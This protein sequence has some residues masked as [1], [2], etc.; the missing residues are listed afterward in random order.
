MF[1]TG[2]LNVFTIASCFLVFS[3]HSEEANLKVACISN[4]D[5]KNK[6][7]KEKIVG[8]FSFDTFFKNT[9]IYIGFKRPFLGINE[10][11]ATNTKCTASSNGGVVDP[12]NGNVATHIVCVEDT[13]IPGERISLVVKNLLGDKRE[14]SFIPRQIFVESKDKQWSLNVEALE[15]NIFAITISGIE[16]G[17][18]IKVHAFSGNEVI[19]AEHEAHPNIPI[20]IFPATTGA[21][22]GISIVRIERSEGRH[23]EVYLPWGTELK[24]FR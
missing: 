21:S 16:P 3:N 20:M 9:D 5:L 1:L 10:E 13:F 15:W 24:K 23:L 18:L 19:K 2:L 8:E 6:E 11:Q 4:A 7:G 22:G 17:E 12:K 14:L